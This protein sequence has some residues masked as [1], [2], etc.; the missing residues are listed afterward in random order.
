MEHPMQLEP[1]RK[2]TLEAYADT[3]IPGEKRWSGDHAVAGVAR[4]GGAV[5]AGALD[6][7]QTAAGGLA[8]ALVTL[9]DML[10]AHAAAYA[11]ESGLDASPELPAFVALDYEHRAALVSRLCAPGHPEKQGWVNLAVFSNMAFDSA[12]H[13]HT[14]DALAS[15]HPG[16]TAMGFAKPDPDGLWRFPE[17]SYGRVLA[18]PH[19][20]TTVSGSPA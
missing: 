18:P 10:N 4:G 1:G 17:Y 16:L 3:I 9:A 15:G 6:L 14:A 2:Q 20:A 7:L 5:A 19:P 13:M 8:D 11:A 12:A